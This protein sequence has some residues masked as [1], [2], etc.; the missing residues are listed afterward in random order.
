MEMK[1]D[2]Y[3]LSSQP[4][5]QFWIHT[6]AKQLC[7]RSQVGIKEY[8]CELP[9]EIKQL[10]VI[11]NG[12]FLVSEDNDIFYYDI[13]KIFESWYWNFPLTLVISNKTFVLTQETVEQGE[14]ERL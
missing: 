9:V 8:S 10:F 12:L 1:I 14:Q 5:C 4:P 2:G 13:R 6:S 3:V 7:I 11:N